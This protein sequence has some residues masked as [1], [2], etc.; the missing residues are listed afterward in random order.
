MNEGPPLLSLYAIPNCQCHTPSSQVV[1]PQRESRLPP[2]LAHPRS[3]AKS[4]WRAGRCN[5]YLG[6]IGFLGLMGLVAV[7]G[8]FPPPLSHSTHVKERQSV[9][10]TERLIDHYSTRG[11]GPE[12]LRTRPQALPQSDLERRVASTYG[13]RPRPL[14]AWRRKEGRKEGRRRRNGDGEN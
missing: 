9:C 1:R 11:A 14:R 5:I 7:G 12:P 6:F 4:P 13:A 10:I 2:S 3:T 8:S